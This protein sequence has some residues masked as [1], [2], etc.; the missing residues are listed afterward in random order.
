MEAVK[1]LAQAKDKQDLFRL[2]EEY[3]SRKLA[4]VPKTEPATADLH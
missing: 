3:K 1:I 4:E 2:A